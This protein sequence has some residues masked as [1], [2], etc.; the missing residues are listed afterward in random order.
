MDI[1]KLVQV[2]LNNNQLNALISFVYNVGINAFKVSLMLRLLNSGADKN[3]VA[4][5]FDRWVFD[6]GVKVK[7]LINRR[8]A[9]K[10][11]F[12]S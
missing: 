10:K 4:A 6:N 3:T 1:K 9:E 5:Q 11:L 8:N 2:P 7:G 12:L